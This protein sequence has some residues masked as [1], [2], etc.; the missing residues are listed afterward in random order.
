MRLRPF[1]PSLRA[2]FDLLNLLL[3][4][5]PYITILCSV[6]LLVVSAEMRRRLVS[7]CSTER[8]PGYVVFPSCLPAALLA[9]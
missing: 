8:I 9:T 6:D 5:F 3:V 1:L 7:E 2:V 4:I